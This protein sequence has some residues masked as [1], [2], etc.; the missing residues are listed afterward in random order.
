MAIFPFTY[1]GCPVYYGR[2]NAAH[3]EE[4]LRTISR[5]IS[6]WQNKFLSFGGKFILV[7]HVLQFVP[8]HLDF[9]MN[10]PTKIINQIHKIFS[11]FF[12]GKVGGVKGKHWVK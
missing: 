2:K 12:W 10:P 8:I 11:F 6:C 9:V 1:L 3:F 5:R 4:V 7:N